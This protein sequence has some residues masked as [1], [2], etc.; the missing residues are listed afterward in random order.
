M[1]HPPRRGF[2]LGIMLRLIEKWNDMCRSV[3]YA[4]LQSESEERMLRDMMHAT[5]S[6]LHRIDEQ[7]VMQCMQ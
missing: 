5:H 3:L 7:R 6:L 2:A 1:T 4:S